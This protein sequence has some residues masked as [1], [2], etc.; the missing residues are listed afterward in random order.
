M[1][2][3]VRSAS[4]PWSW[5]RPTLLAGVG[6]VVTVAA[7]VWLAGPLALVF[8]G[9]LAVGVF[10]LSAPFAFALGQVLVFG[11]VTDGTPAGILLAQSGLL[12]ILLS[13]YASMIHSR[14]YQLA[15]VAAIAIGGAVGFLA[16]ILGGDVWVVTTAG[17]VL[18]SLTAYG[19]HRFELVQLDL[20]LEDS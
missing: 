12:L 16:V 14:R 13:E 15:T 6:T 11:V 10:A 17:V 19:L 1:S 18:A 2:T 8:G 9:V 20:V 3:S 7:W 4:G 5:S